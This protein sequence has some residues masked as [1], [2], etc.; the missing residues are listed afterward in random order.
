MATVKLYI[1]KGPQKG[2]GI[3]LSESGV[4]SFDQTTILPPET[5]KDE[6]TEVTTLTM[7]SV[8]TTYKCSITLTKLSYRKNIYKPCKIHAEL[9]VS[10]LQKRTSHVTQEVD[11]DKNGVETPRE[12]KRDDGAFVDTTSI[13]HFFEGSQV[14]L[15]IN[16][17]TVAKNYMVFKVRTTY[18]T[19]SNKTSQ[20]VNLTIFS[21]DKLMDLNKY[22][23][24]Y[25]ARKLYGEI[26]ATES[27]KFIFK[28]SMYNPSDNPLKNHL[29]DLGTSIPLSQMIVNHMQLLKFRGEETKDNV[30]VNTWTERDEL[31]IPYLVQYNE[32]FY[33]FMARSA[34][35]FGEFLYFE[36]G[37]LNMGMQ[38]LETNYY[39]KDSTDI[40]DWA[41]G[42]NGVQ[43]RYYESV[44]S[45]GVA[46]ED[47]AYNYVEHSPEFEGAYAASSDSRYN[48][49]PVSVDEW[50][51][52][53]LN[54]G[55][56]ITMGEAMLEE[57]KTFLTETIF[58]ALN[59]TTF[60]EAMTT[61]GGEFIKKIMDCQKNNRDYNH[62][63]EH[64]NYK[65]KGEYKIFDDQRSSDND[66]YNQFATYSGSTNL[67]DNLNT[68]FNK[69]DI[70]NFTELFYSLIRSKEK[71]TGEKAVWLDFGSN[72]KPINL[73]DLLHVDDTDYVAIYVGGSYEIVKEK[74]EEGTE[75]S[76]VQE[77]LLVSAI[78]VLKL[79]KTGSYETKDHK[80]PWTN[81]L[82]FPPYLSD[83]L[84][85]DARP[86]VAFVAETL[87]PQ[88]MGRIRVRY[89]W[90]DKD[91]DASP[92]IR[93][94]L[95]LAT[96]GGAVN[97][98][99]NV[100]DEVMVGY[101]YGNIERPYGMGYLVAPFVN[102]RWKNALP[103]DQ[104]GGLH[105]IKVKTGH[106][107]TFTDGAN[108]AALVAST[109]GALSFAK[110]F[111]PTGFLGAWPIGGEITSDFG[112][113]FELSDRYGFYKISGSTDDRSVTIESPVG[114]VEV[115]AFQGITISAPNGDIEIKGKN[116]S[117]S[118]SNQLS[119]SSG[120]T[121]KDKLWYQKK[122]DKTVKS[123]LGAVGDLL[124]DTG[125][126]LAES[127][128]KEGLGT[129]CDLSFLRCFLEWLV[130][131][132]NGTLSIKS[133]TFVTIEAGDGNVEVPP[134]S[135]RSY[136]P[137]TL[138]KVLVTT[139]QIKESVYARLLDIRGKYDKLCDATQAFLAISG[140]DGINKKQ[141][142]IKF[143]DI[144]K[145]DKA[146]LQEGDFTWLE[147]INDNDNNLKGR[148][149]YAPTEPK[150]DDYKDQ[151]GEVDETKFLQAKA[152][153]DNKIKANVRIENEN[154]K[155]TVDREKVIEVSKKLQKAAKALSDAAGKWTDMTVNDFTYGPYPE[156]DA[157]TA[158]EKIKA[159]DIIPDKG[160]VS[161][162]AMKEG[163]YDSTIGK[164]NATTWNNQ[165]I[166]LYRYIISQYLS[167]QKV[168]KS[169]KTI[170]KSV[171]DASKKNNWE[172]YANSVD[173]D[174]SITLLGTLKNGLSWANENL[175]TFKGFK[176]DQHKWKHGFKGR[177]LISDQ[178]DKTASFSSDLTM[179]SHTNQTFD[180][181]N[182]AALQKLLKES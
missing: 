35:R 178:A 77:H 1:F 160:I 45:E 149:L 138:Y 97:F 59:S 162:K 175:N 103:L 113:G 93:V 74:N 17:H 85:R 13:S 144:V 182:L 47:R 70:T 137:S 71:E 132:I 54:N 135:L 114:T 58:M 87:D 134:E 173:N 31:R 39:K 116:V 107:L 42:A 48:M 106:H 23:R 117:I 122:W 156:A 141:S 10:S 72:Y 49:D 142:A 108:M 53:D 7:K 12:E 91:G 153:Y 56:Y 177:I 152:N 61:F 123:K 86:Q 19:V 111:Y 105:G 98:T 166:A 172:D 9:E 55:D 159:A 170:I 41:D 76:K 28:D 15:E 124:K 24:A 115:N 21:A 120:E 69:D 109:F 51:K 20:F 84:I 102:E 121:I 140:D 3:T 128:V 83:V 22:S 130:H 82:P 143:S 78:P 100:G 110:T 119:I 126:E 163:S 169:D 67:Q 150:K 167:E 151:N 73:G 104:Y 46:V 118:A 34:N 66:H 94:T 180:E 36:D 43:S 158:C 155:R 52:Q 6:T 125:K 95:P 14:F 60:A 145:A 5:K 16:D 133:Y 63:L 27:E 65:E 26:L 147:G 146:E 29:K 164:A 75:V 161:L 139:K 127:A 148:P 38:P 25:T 157:S 50:T 168:I 176:D 32:T 129:I 80:E 81:V 88:N 40:I 179:K 96:T 174:D 89:P 44:L 131:P 2:K 4:F 64:A 33:R 18:K 8:V 57:A 92:W 90:Q 165:A 112:G 181:Q 62:V 171:D 136:E 11:I 99:P 79:E 154:I 30:I 37:K 101:E 68:L